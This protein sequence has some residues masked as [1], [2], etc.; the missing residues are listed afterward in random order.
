MDRTP[1]TGRAGSSLALVIGAFLVVG[2]LV[3][4]VTAAAAGDSLRF[5]PTNNAPA[6]GSTFS[7]SVISNTTATISGASASVTFDKARL[8]VMDITEGPDWASATKFGWPS[9]VNKATFIATANGVGKVPSIG[10]SFLDGTSALT[11]GDHVLY[12]VTFKLL[13]CGASTPIGLPVGPTDGTI[14]SGESAT[15]GEAL[16]ITSAG[17]TVQRACATTAPSPSGSASTSPTPT[18]STP[19]PTS[20]VAAETATPDPTLP[21]TDGSASPGEGGRTSILVLVLA[22]I[23]VI[24]AI[25]GRAPAERRDREASP[26]IQRAA[27]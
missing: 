12:T 9:A 11:S 25:A 3:L 8:E 23:L 16:T 6:N 18:P 21:P 15:Y 13:S 10:F 22:G 20:S 27:R 7:V 26:C 5:S 2:S 24:A 14:L 19:A 1:R 4:P 17:G